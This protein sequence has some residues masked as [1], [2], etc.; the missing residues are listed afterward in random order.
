VL[1]VAS[2]LEGV[3]AATHRVLILFL[4]G[5]GAALLAVAAGGWLLARSALRPVAR[6]TSHA[7]RIEVDSLGERVPVPSSSDEIAHLAMTLNNML[8]RLDRGVGEKRRLVADASHELR[9]PLAAMRSELDVAIA[10]DDLDPAAR[11]VLASTRDEV[12]RMSRTVENLLTLARADDGRLELRRE[13][14]DLHDV[15][16]EVRVALAPVAADTGV[17]VTSAGAGG[18]VEA[19]RERVRQIVVNFVDNALKHSPR[20]GEVR[21]VTWRADGEECLSVSDDGAG[22]PGDALEHVFERFYRVDSAR[23]RETGGSGLGLAICRE[24]ARAHGGRV[25][26]ETGQGRGSRFTLALPVA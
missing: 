19:D 6:L 17:A 13:P 7:A 1:L 2:S 22:I 4:L 5:G 26:A 20:G 25:W 18:I 9:T 23:A 21:V 3:D 16:D 10:Y 12:E 11:A 8:D 15:A 24:I 14:L